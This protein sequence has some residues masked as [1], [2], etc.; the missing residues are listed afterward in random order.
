MGEDS[1][2]HEGRS[3]NIRASYNEL[4]VIPT[5]PMQVEEREEKEGIR[6][7]ATEEG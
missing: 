3:I 2:P 5:W 1:V 7:M 4:V 6:K